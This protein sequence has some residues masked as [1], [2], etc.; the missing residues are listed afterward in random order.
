MAQIRPF[1]AVH[2]NPQVVGDLADV[3]APPYDIISPEQQEALYAASQYNCV[4]LILGKESPSDRPWENRYTRAAGHFSSWLKKG[5]LTRDEEPAL[6]I[7]EQHYAIREGA[8]CRRLAFVALVKLEDFSSGGV[9]PHERTLAGPK[10][11]RFKLMDAAN[12]NFCQI[13]GLYSDPNDLEGA[14]LREQAHGEPMTD[15]TD[16]LGIRNLVWRVTQPDII[17]KIAS[18]LK[19]RRIFIADGHHRYETALNYRN[20]QRE[21]TGDTSGEAAFDYVMMFLANM[22]GEG[23]TVLP[24]HR[25]LVKSGLDVPETEKRLMRYFDIERGH[26]ETLIEEMRERGREHHVFGIYLGTGKLYVLTLKNAE[27]IR[28][29]MAG[30]VPEWQRLDP[31]ILHTVIISDVLGEDDTELKDSGRISFTPYL[32]EAIAT[33][34][35]GKV[36]LAIFL[37]PV[38]IEQLK[39]V[40]GEG[41]KMPQ[42]STYFYPKPLSGLLFN[43][44]EW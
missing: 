40:A 35:S 34:D 23:I 19:G 7:Y 33:V 39:R 20:R 5:A 31:A 1:R 12:A 8:V 11:D 28:D 13:F 24:A 15:L 22:D 18:D 3:V 27:L 30:H 4:R 17:T 38:T 26:P 21:K 43:Q 6:Y 42:K 2:Y 16:A 37:N 29:L 14:L 41:E 32:E 25:L 36:D 9:V 44:L 10:T